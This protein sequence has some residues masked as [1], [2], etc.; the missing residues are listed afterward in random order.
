VCGT[1]ESIADITPQYLYTC[2]HTFYHPSNMMLVVCGEVDLSKVEALVDS[3]VKPLPKREIKRYFK[4]EPENIVSNRRTLHMEVARPLFAIGVKDVSPVIGTP[5]AVRRGL[6][7][8]LISEWIFGT[9]SAFYERLYDEGLL[10]SRFSAGYEN[11]RTCAFFLLTGEASD[12]EV[13]YEHVLE[14]FNRVCSTPPAQEDFLR[15]RK[16][17]YA[18]Y[19]R[20]FDSTEDI[21]NNLLTYAMMEADLL[22][23]GEVINGITYEETIEAMRELFRKERFAMAT[24]LP[25]RESAEI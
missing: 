11:Y 21:A 2:Y 9:S 14:E 17:M 6:I 18:E 23:V 5:D 13:I 8:A 25:K 3:Y 4:A 15:V 22:D 19:V 10:N 12:P 24:V 7:F 1:Q 20:D 16:A